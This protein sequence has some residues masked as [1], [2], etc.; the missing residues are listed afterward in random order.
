MPSVPSISTGIDDTLRSVMVL[1]FLGKVFK[2]LMKRDM[3][4]VLP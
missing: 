2:G 3:Q 4:S 1:N